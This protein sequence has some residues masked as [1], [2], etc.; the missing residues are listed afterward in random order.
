MFTERELRRGLKTKTFG[1]KIYAFETIDST[2]NCGK[3]LA[4][5][6]ALEGVVIIAEEQTA[7]KGRLGRTWQANP[8]ENLTFSLLLRPR[9]SPDALNLLPL[10]IA[11]AVAEA[12]ERVVDLKVECKW[13]NDLLVN[14]KKIGGILIEGSVKENIVEHV[15]IGLGLNVNQTQFSPDFKTRA[16]SLRLESRQQVDRTKLFREVISLLETQYKSYAKT[17]FRSVIPL[18]EKRSTMLNKPIL[19]SQ[20]GNVFSG[21][22]KGL[23]PEGGLVL[24]TDGMTKTLFA[25]DVTILG[26]APEQLFPLSTSPSHAMA[27]SKA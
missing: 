19:V 1:N 17:A 13:P 18:W 21:T 16:T 23:S 26:D 4:S 14:G 7:G 9:V 24:E 5:V 15:V 2:N 27:A 3:V 10:Y 25:G 6:G 22:V 20:S 11:V 12:I 8:G